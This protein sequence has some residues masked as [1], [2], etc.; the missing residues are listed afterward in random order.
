MSHVMSHVMRSS[1]GAALLATATLAAAADTELA[2]RVAACARERD[3][4]ARLACFDRLTGKTAASASSAPAA[5]AA[6]PAAAATATPAP[7]PPK[8]AA[9]AGAAGAAATAA[10]PAAKSAAADFGVSGSEVARQRDAEAQKQPGAPEK[11]DRINA[12]VTAISKRP[13]GELVVTLDN[14]QVWAQKEVQY[15][16]VKVGDQVTIL[17]GALHS[18]KMVVAGRATAVTRIQ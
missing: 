12:A 6:E 16:P 13:R 4:V 7:A 18:Y 10:T 8:A 15:V 11:I 3:D 14:G 5:K 2:E 9:T 17:A 1:F